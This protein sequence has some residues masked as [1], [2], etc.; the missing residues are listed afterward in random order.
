V[1]AESILIERSPARSTVGIE[2]PTHID[3]RLCCATDRV[4]EFIN[5]PS[6]MTLALART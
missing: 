3:R 4:A 1:K 6:K 2:V 5:S